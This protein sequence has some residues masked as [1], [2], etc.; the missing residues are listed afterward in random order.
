MDAAQ[1][2]EFIFGMLFLERASDQF[3]EVRERFIDRQLALGRS[4]SEAEKIA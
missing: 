1:Y 2:Q 3:D 4:R